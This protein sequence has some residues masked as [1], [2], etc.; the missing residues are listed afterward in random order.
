MGEAGSCF[1]IM[2]FREPFDSYYS[3]II[4]PAARQS[5]FSVSRS[6]EVYHPQAFVQTIWDCIITADVVIAEMTGVNPNVLYEL[7][8]CHAIDKTVIMLAQ[9]IEHIPADLRHINC[10]I[11]DTSRPSWALGMKKK[12]GKM[13]G[14]AH[15]S[16]R[17]PYLR[18]TPIFD[19]GKRLSEAESELARQKQRYG[20]CTSALTKATQATETERQRAQLLDAQVKMLL[21]RDGSASSQLPAAVDAE[22]DEA[23]FRV[24]MHPVRSTGLHIELVEVPSGH[25]IHGPPG[26][27]DRINLP[28]FFI[29]RFSITNE[30]FAAFL[31]EC[32]NQTEYGTSWMD[33]NGKS[34]ADKCRIYQQGRVF[35]VEGSYEKHPA[36]YV[37]Y[38]GASAFCEWAGGRLP[39]ETEWEK[40]ARGQDG[41]SYP[42]GNEPPDGDRTNFGPTAWPRDVAPVA[43]DQFPKGISPYG[44]YQMIGNVWH[45]TSTYFLD[46]EVQ[47]VRGGAFFDFRVGNR[48]VYRFLVQPDGPDFSQGF[49]FVKRF[50]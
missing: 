30:L 29:S 50:L 4:Q 8:L 10:L 33:L 13:I 44:C 31:N 22:V 25:F 27:R 28:T 48:G 34:A 18:P 11:Y 32:G 20:E 46:R 5:G 38:Y 41:R 35:L 14:A 39:T 37:N 43:V 21:K 49:C 19:H 45:W 17:T 24:Y 26:S 42:W 16:V 9:S 23:R 15:V 2:P 36:T 40:A 6:D 3:Q 7:G 1:V 47:A 12:L